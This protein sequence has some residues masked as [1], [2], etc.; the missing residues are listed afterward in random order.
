MENNK[1]LTRSTSD[2]WIA[3][4][5]AGIANYFGWDVAIFRLIYLLLTVCTAFCGVVAYIILWICMPEDNGYN[6]QTRY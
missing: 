5:C 2:R 4:V 3:G 1:K 6:N